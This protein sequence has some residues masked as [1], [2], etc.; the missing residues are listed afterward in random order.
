[1]VKRTREKKKRATGTVRQF[2]I[3]AYEE[4]KKKTRRRQI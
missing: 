1:M 3:E 2:V 4:K